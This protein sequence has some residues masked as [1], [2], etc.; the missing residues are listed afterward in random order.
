MEQIKPIENI[1]SYR[2][3]FRSI[4]LAIFFCFF[5]FENALSQT[6]WEC[7]TPTDTNIISSPSRGQNCSNSGTDF[8]NK[9]RTPAYW[10]PNNATPIKTILVNYII[11]Q[12]SGGGNA[13]EDTPAIRAT[14]NYMFELVNRQFANSQPKGYPSTCQP[15][16]NNISDTRI[17][18]ELNEI[19]FIQNSSYNILCS[20][21]SANIVDTYIKA[22]FPN[23]K[24]AINHIFTAGTCGSHLGY[25]D[26]SYCY[27]SSKMYMGQ[28]MIHPDYI[29]HICHEYGHALGL[30]HTYDSEDRV[31]SSFNFL[32]DIFGT[33]Y[34]PYIGP[35]CTATPSIPISGWVNYLPS[36]FFQPYT[37][38]VPLLC[39]YAGDT[40]SSYISPKSQG[41]MHRV[42]SLY[43]NSWL[44]N[45]Q[46]MHQYVKEKY[47]YAIPLEITSNETWD[48]AIKLYQDIVVKS[49]ST[50]TIQCEVKM[51][52]NGKIIVERGATL[53]ID[54]GVIDCGWDNAM[55]QGIEVWGNRNASQLTAGAQGKVIMKNNAVIENSIDGIVTIRKDSSGNLDWNYTGGIVQATNSE[56]LN[57]RN[58]ATFLSYHN[59]H[60]ITGNTMNNI[61][62]FKNCVFK[63]DNQLKDITRIPDAGISMYDIV[64]LRILGCD[65]VNTTNDIVNSGRRGK[66]ILSYDA[67]FTVDDLC[68]GT[69]FPCNTFKQNTF[70]D[71]EYG[72]YCS[73]A[74][75][76]YAPYINH[77]KFKGNR[78]DGIHLSGV[79]YAT[80]QNCDFDVSSYFDYGGASGL[81]LD[82]CKYYTVQN[83][84]FHTTESVG[85][86]GIYVKDSKT[87]AHE[88]YNNTFEG[89]HVG[90]EPLR[91]NSGISNF[92]DGLTMHCNVFT[93]NQFDIAVTGYTNPALGK[94]SLA[95]IQGLNIL[96]T[97]P[98]MALVRNTY[99]AACGSE[100][101]YFMVTNEPKVVQHH[102]NSE[103]YTRPT[104]QPSCSDNLV[105]VVNSGIGFNRSLHCPDL[106]QL[107]NTLLTAKIAQTTGEI[108]QL[109]QSY[110]NTIDGGN[111]NA[112]LNA[113]YSNM[114]P[115]NLKN[116]LISKSPYLSDAVL[117]AYLTKTSTP[118]NGH[119]KEIV[120]ANS[121]V[122][123]AVKEKIDLLNLPPGIKN[124]INAAQTKNLSSRQ[125]LEARI[126]QLEYD[127]QLRVSDKI[128]YFLNDTLETDPLD[129]LIALIK[130][131]PRSDN[132]CEI[133]SAYVTKGDYTKAQAVVDS[134][135][136]INQVDDFCA[137]QKIILQLNQ[138]TEKC[139]KL[140]TDAALKDKVEEI[141]GDCTKDG[142][143]NAQAL[144]KQVFNYQYQELRMLPE[145]N[146]SV[147]IETEQIPNVLENGLSIYPNPANDFVNIVFNDD[148]A[149]T[150][151][152]EIKDVLGKT[153]E[154]IYLKVAESK[155]YDTQMLKGGVYFF[156]L[157]IND[158]VIE[159]KKI[160]LVK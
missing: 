124:Q 105:N 37:T 61:S 132:P 8:L 70:T 117:M 107:N 123:E 145:E 88:L 103:A 122:T 79:Y 100:N 53:V 134:L 57:C 20:P 33:C 16:I 97:P 19:V 80:I 4:F 22:N 110:N 18:F 1:L 119:I 115:G 42:L 128:R 153:I 25:Y 137:F 126:V 34:E 94:N 69:T 29:N 135:Q 67:K 91:D 54:G 102:A 143:C 140:Q 77:T 125:F 75:V 41:R 62:F 95:W 56:F 45:C 17:R 74:N 64:G 139:F 99:S 76:F 58:G 63:I 60:P 44:L 142:C 155:M 86:V 130:Q 36:C 15:P 50:L 84:Y 93:S 82:Y 47:S 72:V 108:N 159:N 7:A 78:F 27:V 85:W 32:D 3:F 21:G 83:N 12:D 96:T 152:M 127:K 35:I 92:S 10:I 40:C 11:C 24:G 144:L 65:F 157:Y 116:L 14:I 31:I 147:L 81:Y 90:I 30:Q 39:G 133:V 118:P 146:R 156:T 160:V 154:T 66:G 129:S 46:P 136:A 55:W 113:I 13:W 26:P 87:G 131:Y 51:P 6:I 104:P 112:L 148:E 89:L 52:I 141:A 73:N 114:S 23:L 98:G 106:T 149:E 9:Y 71:M 2:H 68:T 43:N 59:F 151:V 120:I 49:G 48:F 150:A 111:T 101:Q 5:T 109:R 138:S 158:K 28:Y 121:P 38:G